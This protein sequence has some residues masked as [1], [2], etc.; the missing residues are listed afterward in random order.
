[1]TVERI[2]REHPAVAIVVFS[3]ALNLA[4]A[5]LQAGVN[6]YVLKEIL[7]E[8]LDLAVHTALAGEVFISEAVTTYLQ[9]AK[10]RVNTFKLLPQELR[11]LSLMSQGLRTLEIALALGIEANTVQNYITSLR[12]KTGCAER[13]QLINWYRQLYGDGSN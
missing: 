11:V 3:S 8:Q 7:V 2:R 6:G 10:S 9:N 12:R 5:L 1:M 4:P 13:T